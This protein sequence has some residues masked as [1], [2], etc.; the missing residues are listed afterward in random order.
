MIPNKYSCCMLVA[1]TIMC[2]VICPKDKITPLVHLR[3]PIACQTIGLPSLSYL[4][5]SCS[6]A[7]P[8]DLPNAKASG[9]GT[10]LPICLTC[11]WE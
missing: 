10:A 7:S 4:S 5:H 6:S 3:F 1:T 9:T 2:I 11:F 8:I